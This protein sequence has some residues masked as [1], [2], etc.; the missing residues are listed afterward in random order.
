MKGD[1]FELRGL[2]VENIILSASRLVTR[3]T[4]NLIT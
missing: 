4:S 1:T 3:I 2:G